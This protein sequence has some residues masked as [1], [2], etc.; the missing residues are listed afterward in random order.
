LNQSSHEHQDTGGGNPAKESDMPSS[1]RAS[2]TDKDSEDLLELLADTASP[3]FATNDEQRIVFWNRGAEQLFGRDP[4]DTVGLACFEVVQ[5]RDAFGNRFCYRECPVMT[6]HRWGEPVTGCEFVMPIG[7]EGTGVS[8]TLLQ[9]PGRGRCTGQLVHILR[10]MGGA[11]LRPLPGG[12]SFP[13]RVLGSPQ[14]AGQTFK[15]G[16]GNGR[17]ASAAGN[18]NGRHQAAAGSSSRSEVRQITSMASN[19]VPPLTSREAEILR[20]VAA[21]LPNKEVARTLGISLATVRNHIHSILEK[22]EVHSKLEA[23]SLA[24]RRGWVSGDP[25]AQ[26]ELSVSDALDA[27]SA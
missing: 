24:F 11:A 14:E 3:A 4:A 26:D 25:A 20:W 10:P 21:G 18:G 22:L 16:N 5:G 8:V 6:T 13:G 7:E 2:G 23:V 9:I 17:P 15:G 27:E 1:R 12:R 19:D